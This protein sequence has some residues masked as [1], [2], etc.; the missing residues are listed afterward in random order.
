MIQI[1]VGVVAIPVIL[2]V[3]AAIGYGVMAMSDEA[4]ISYT[5]LGMFG[6]AVSFGLI[7]IVMS[8]AFLVVAYLIGTCVCM[9][10]N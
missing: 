4:F 3:V 2:L 10:F 6:E 7:G 1:L 9:I 8:T 5:K